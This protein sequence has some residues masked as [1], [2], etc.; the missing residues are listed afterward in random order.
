M[1]Q[2]PLRAIQATSWTNDRPTA[3]IAGVPVLEGGFVYSRELSGGRCG[4]R[5]RDL[6]LVRA[7]LFQL[8]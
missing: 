7:A 4:P 6:R 8:S 3:T 2:A 1:N 5:S